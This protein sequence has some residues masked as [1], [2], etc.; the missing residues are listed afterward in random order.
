[1]NFR[2]KISFPADFVLFHLTETDDSFL[3]VWERQRFNVFKVISKL[4]DIKIK[5]E[6]RRKIRLLCPWIVSSKSGEFF[7]M[8]VQLTVHKAL[9]YAVYVC[10]CA[11]SVVSNSAT[12]SAP[13]SMEFSRQ[14]YWSS[15]LFSF[16]GNLLDPRIK[17]VSLAS[18]AWQASSLAAEP[19]LWIGP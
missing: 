6:F 13:L 3:Q 12:P 5:A 1:M 10:M 11:Y 9:N 8:W 7:L 18:P 4:T 16:P 19:P 17:P 2:N 14:E 15:L